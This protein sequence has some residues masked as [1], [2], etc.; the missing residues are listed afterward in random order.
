M[1]LKP[2]SN[3]SRD[4]GLRVDEE[5]KGSASR[6]PDKEEMEDNIFANRLVQTRPDSGN[7][8]ENDRG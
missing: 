2:T 4:G 8:H 3:K 1:C 5:E 7:N 6:S